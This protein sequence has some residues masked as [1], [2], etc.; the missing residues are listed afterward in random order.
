MAHDTKPVLT[1][2]RV[3]SLVQFHMQ[4]VDMLK[5]AKNQGRP[6]MAVKTPGTIMKFEQLGIMSASLPQGRRLR[7]VTWTNR[8]VAQDFLTAEYS[9]ASKTVTSEWLAAVYL[10]RQW[11]RE[12]V[13]RL[14]LPHG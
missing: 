7:L 13:G 9:G 14:R 5:A 3:N 11:L 8:V 4:G 2:S 10:S 6:T 1:T 12:R